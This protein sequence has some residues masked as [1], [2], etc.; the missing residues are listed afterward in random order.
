MTGGTERWATGQFDSLVRPIATM[1]IGRAP[2]LVLVFHFDSATPA[3][4]QRAQ[5][6]TQ[7]WPT[8]PDNLH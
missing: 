8:Y 5:L 2:S 7:W 1:G 6:G 4:S 3:C